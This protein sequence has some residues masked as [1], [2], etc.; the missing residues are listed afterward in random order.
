MTPAELDRIILPASP[1][2]GID[3]LNVPANRRRAEA[4]WFDMFA[5]GTERFVVSSGNVVGGEAET[6]ALM[7]VVRA[8]FDQ[9]SGESSTRMLLQAANA[10]INRR[11]TPGAAFATAIVGI[12]DC[13]ERTLTYVSA[14]HPPPF[15]RYHNGTVAK[16]PADSLSARPSG[17]Q[18]PPAQVVVDLRDAALVLLYSSALAQ[19][20]PDA[21]DGLRRIGQ[22]LADERMAHCSSPAA[23]IARQ[24]LG[25]VSH[26]EAALL[27]L[28]LAPDSSPNAALQ[29]GL[30][31]WT[32]AWS[33][34]SRSAASNG[35]RRAFLACLKSKDTGGAPVDFAAAE[36]IFGELLGNVVRHAPGRVDII[37]DWTNVLPVL[38]V[39]DRGPG[40]RSRRKRE[41]LPV[42]ELSESGRG[43]FIVNACAPQFSV[44]NRNGRGTHASATLPL[45]S[46]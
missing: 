28:T 22:V 37:L 31:H 18:H 19:A 32:A 27:A 29:G 23:W 35:A 13:L 26:D 5:L 41:R 43:L 3:A 16:L 10:V 8:A 1:V 4:A 17:C 15:V 9:D 20:A 25:N 45:A 2:L 14:G 40:F 46:P 12:I 6:S 39:L 21:G 11:S 33:F 7:L 36:L 24:V 30:P 38:H 44:H 34:D 42:D